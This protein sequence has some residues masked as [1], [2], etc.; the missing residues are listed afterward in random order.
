M[1]KGKTKNRERGLIAPQLR[2]CVRALAIIRD[3]RGTV[4]SRCRRAESGAIFYFC[5]A[6]T[7]ARLIFFEH[8]RAASRAVH[9]GLLTREIHRSPFLPARAGERARDPQRSR[10]PIP[11]LAWFFPQLFAARKQLARARSLSR[12]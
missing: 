12:N 10:S 6:N 4:T 7:D 8:G 5:P 9:R 3:R 2:R 11:L 1:R